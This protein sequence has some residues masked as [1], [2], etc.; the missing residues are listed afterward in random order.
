[1]RLII[2]LLILFIAGL[3][4]WFIFH[5]RNLRSGVKALEKGQYDEAITCFDDSIADD[6][7]VAECWRGKGMAYYEKKDYKKAAKC[8]RTALDEGG[9]EDAQI[10]NLIALSLIN[11]GKYK[12]SIKW[13]ESGL[14][15][16][17][18]SEELIQEMRYQLV[19]VYEK[20][21]QWE[22]AR[23]NAES[24]TSDYPDDQKM[25][26]EYRFLQTR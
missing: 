1:M 12:S 9:T 11:Q 18:A 24:Y 23:E 8:L 2:V 16:S 5:D 26:R 13:L 3:I 20:T 22:L 15:Q 7:N 25:I 21:G 17:D 6:K 19:L 10:C 14:T 4:A